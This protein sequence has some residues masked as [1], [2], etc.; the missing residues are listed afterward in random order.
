MELEYEKGKKYILLIDDNRDEYELIKKYLENEKIGVC[1]SPE[2][3]N[4]FE[5]AKGKHIS[6]I[7]VDFKMPGMD[8]REFC[9]IAKEDS[10]LKFSPII[11]FSAF[12]DTE[13]MIKGLQSGA[14]D[15]LPKILPR[16][17]LVEK[18]KTYVRIAD[19]MEELQRA[20]DEVRN[21]KEILPVCGW[22]KKI[23]DDEGYWHE[24][25][26]YLKKEVDTEV[27]HGICADCK[28]KMMEKKKKLI[29]F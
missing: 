4:S 13:N 18:I 17:L 22:C 16:E 14:D 19:L 21:L 9:R 25:E 7:L 11:M 29:D 20:K 24:L 3:K 2:A 8:G 1:Y 23:R 5:V 15:Y 28:K 27:S 12:N 10:I 6:C 26:T